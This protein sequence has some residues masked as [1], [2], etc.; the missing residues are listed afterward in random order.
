[1]KRFKVMVRNG[2]GF[3]I[4][5][6]GLYL[7]GWEIYTCS[8]EHPV[9]ICAYTQPGKHTHSNSVHP[10]SMVGDLLDNVMIKVMARI[11]H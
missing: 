5:S 6:R 9:H 10:L 8:T 11:Y 4:G 3:D 2:N 1:M 7:G